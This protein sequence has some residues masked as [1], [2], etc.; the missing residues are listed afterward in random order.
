MV[1]LVEE[2]KR[3][4]QRLINALD[5]EKYP[6][7]RTYIGNFSQ[8]AWLAFDCWLERKGWIPMNTNAVEGAFS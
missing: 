1:E 5:P 7:T 2:I 4:F 3:G 6:K 8:N